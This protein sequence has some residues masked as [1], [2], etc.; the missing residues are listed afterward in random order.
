MDGT[1]KQIQPFLPLSFNSD[2]EK[3][4]YTLE[5]ILFVVNRP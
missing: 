4:Q 5:N 2:E 1:D 3:L